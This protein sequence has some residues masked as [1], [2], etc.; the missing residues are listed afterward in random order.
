MFF[1]ETSMGSSI[2][3]TNAHNFGPGLSQFPISVPKA[4]SF[5]RASQGMVLR[6]EVEDQG[7]FFPVG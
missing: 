7:A 1:P 4:T 2:V 5:L 6:I 3:P